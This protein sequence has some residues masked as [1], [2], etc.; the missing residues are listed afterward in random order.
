MATLAENDTD[1]LTIR[2][3]EGQ[4]G[5]VTATILEEPAA[6][7]QGRTRQ[8]AYEN[9]LEALHDLRNEATR[10][11]Q[12]AHRVDELR[13]ALMRFRERLRRRVAV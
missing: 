7:S 12:L 13:D 4:D 9:V 2:Y 8:E 11:E 3:E 6:I 10:A 5:W 1:R